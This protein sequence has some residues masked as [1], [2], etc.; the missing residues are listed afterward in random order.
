MV[1]K[2]PEEKNSKKNRSSLALFICLALIL[3][4]ISLYIGNSLYAD[5]SG[6]SHAARDA[7]GK[8]P[9]GA[10]I[11][12]AGEERPGE[13]LYEA[14]KE[15]DEP[16]APLT[17]A[18]AKPSDI[19]AEE[20][21][22][23]TFACHYP[24]ADRYT[25]ETYDIGN[26]WH[27]A[28]GA[29]IA[30]DELGREASLLRIMANEENDMLTVRCTTEFEPGEPITDTATL[31]VLDKEIQG[32]SAH[33]TTASPGQYISARDIPLAVTYQD[34]SSEELPGLYNVC[35]LERSESSEQ[36][37]TASG[38]TIETIT[39]VIT[40]RGYLKAKL[41]ETDAMLRY[42]GKGKSIDAPVKLIGEDT[43]EPS[44]T[45]LSI[46]DIVISNVDEPVPVTVSIEAEDDC[47]P[48][49][50]LEYAFLP[51]GEEPGE[52][53]WTKDASFEA[54]I[55]QNGKWIAYCRDESGN[56]GSSEKDIIAVD[57]KP[58]SISLKLGNESW[59]ASN[60]ILV[61]AK[62]SLPV[63]YSYSCEETGEESGW[64]DKNE[65]TVRK[66]G[67]WKVKVRDAAGNIAEQEITISN[68]DSQEPII[69]KITEKE[70]ET[71]NNED[72][73]EGN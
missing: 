38:N 40:S 17:D 13:P 43:S 29:M 52:G 9:L 24:D 35:F 55:T 63:E 22:L 6:P 4:A 53:D 57:N 41:G 34:G 46:S 37:A 67:T 26:G 70:G 7:A 19:Y 51:E 65:H 45:Q 33:D 27:E 31:Y 72:E 2:V 42:Q 23:V 5:T 48:G 36:S 8:R 64:T 25:W 39:T 30:S 10:A 18:P 54:D 68:I 73:K 50:G 16:Q 56:I 44:I 59:C 28:E 11:R 32:I 20:G 60:K 12:A 71:T 3:S 62:D 14:K 69:I 21:T 49:P 47:T 66:N 15:E 61:S 1:K 58:P